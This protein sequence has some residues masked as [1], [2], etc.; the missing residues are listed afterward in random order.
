MKKFSIFLS[1]LLALTSISIAQ[2]T[3]ENPEKPLSQKAGRVLKLKEVCRIREE[4]GNFY[5]RTPE[6]L[7]VAA[8]GSII[9]ADEKELLKFSSEGKFIKNLYKEGQGPGEIEDNFGYDIFENKIYIYDFAAQK[10]IQTDL[11]GNLIEQ[12][13]IEPA[14]YQAFYGVTESWFVFLKDIFLSPKERKAKLQDMP[15]AIRLVSKDGKTEKE[16]Y[17]FQRIMFLA[18][19]FV[20]SWTR[21]IS[22]LSEDRKRLYVSH[23]NEYL[24]EVL[25]LETG[26]VI[27]R[28]NRKYPRVPY[29]KRGW[30]DSFYK[31]FKAPKRDFE[32][33]IIG[34]F[35]QNGLLWVRTSTRD[36]KN[37]EMFDIFDEEGR[38]VDTFFPGANVV[39]LAVHKEY[40]YSLEK[41]AAGNYLI[42]KY[43]ILE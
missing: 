18:P 11:E 14:P 23:T 31:R 39:P 16:S 40:L 30:E 24:I 29:T 28:F 8:D 27:K 26:Q 34:L 22:T 25:D 17:V 36:K 6:A 35:V 15:C 12:I 1:C 33:D 13:K 41:D 3:I 37:G 4:M 19:T 32:E 9:V 42:V 38:F 10:V 43:E 2:Q 5:F 21:F 20:V 7:K